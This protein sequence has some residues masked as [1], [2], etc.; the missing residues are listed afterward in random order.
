MFLN[1]TISPHPSYAM[2]MMEMYCYKIHL[3][4]IMG[5]TYVYNF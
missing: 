1:I 3:L 4:L 5:Q 2:M